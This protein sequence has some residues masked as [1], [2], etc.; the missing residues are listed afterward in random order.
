LL[1]A[2]LAGC[3]GPDDRGEAEEGSA[4][5]DDLAELRRLFPRGVLDDIGRWLDELVA[6]RS[7]ADDALSRIAAAI[8]GVE[9][10]ADLQRRIGAYRLLAA[11]HAG[12]LSVLLRNSQ[13][14]HPEWWGTELEKATVVFQDVTTGVATMSGGSAGRRIYTDLLAKIAATTRRSTDDLIRILQSQGDE[15][16]TVLQRVKENF[17]EQDV[18]GILHW[19]RYVT[20]PK[21]PFRSLQSMLVT[22]SHGNG[23]LLVEELIKNVPFRNEVLAALRSGRFYE[24][25]EIIWVAGLASENASADLR[26]VRSIVLTISRKLRSPTTYASGAKTNHPAGAAVLNGGEVAMKQYQVI[27]AGQIDTLSGVHRLNG[28]EVIKIHQVNLCSGHHRPAYGPELTSSLQTMFSF[29]G[30]SLIDVAAAGRACL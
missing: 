16:R 13:P 15:T 11:D 12:Q 18:Q 6:G 27:A 5:V 30:V 20:N 28:R 1:C 10:L 17:T 14:Y 8:R 29:L 19:A 4:S 7:S 22:D 9:A 23:Y 21:N 26:G 25:Y 24:E 3:W 2:L